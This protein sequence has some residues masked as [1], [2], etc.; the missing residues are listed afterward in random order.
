MKKQRRYL[1]WQIAAL[2]LWAIS[3]A[4]MY[5]TDRLYGKSF[6]RSVLYANAALFWVSFFAWFALTLR[7]LWMGRGAGYKRP[8]I[9]CFFRNRPAA[10]ADGAL[11]FL[12]VCSVIL[13]GIG[14]GSRFQLLSFL[15]IAG[16]VFLIGIHSILNGS[17]YAAVYGKENSYKDE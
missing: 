11:L 6:Y 17:H 10:I 2:A 16:F 4:L 7:I 3:I 15:Q 5:G 14:I 12:F 9:F 13:D 8:G 1:R